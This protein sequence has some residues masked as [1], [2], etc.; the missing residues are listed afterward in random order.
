MAGPVPRVTIVVFA[1]GGPPAAGVADLLPEGAHVIAADS[2]L[3]HATALGVEVDRVIG[4]MD[5]VDPTLL[6]GLPPEVRVDRHPAAKDATDLELAIDA[7][8][9]LRPDAIVIVGGH[10][11][12]SD[13]FLANAM[14]LAGP[15]LVGIEIRW[16]AGDDLVH[17]V[18]DTVA[19]QGAPG[20]TV[21]LIPLTDCTGVTTDGL[22]W[23]LESATLPRGTTRGVSNEVVA[24]EATVSVAS[25]SLLV[26]QPG[27]LGAPV[28]QE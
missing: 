2:G 22:A 26:V 17:V 3:D 24:T 8:L 15:R 1:G 14:L 23:H 28:G 10:G 5:S 18:D 19:L 25:G 20:S 7:A 13:H 4:D 27:A 11:G 21:S 16:L 12:R 6:A 9:A